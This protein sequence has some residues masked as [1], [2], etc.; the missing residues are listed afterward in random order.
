MRDALLVLRHHLLE[1]L[2]QA[3]NQA[4]SAANDV[5]AALML[6]L[7]Q[8]FV[9]ASFQFVHGFTHSASSRILAQLIR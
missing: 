4:V 1:E 7:F 9:Q 6:M 5:Q 2:G 8:N 3:G